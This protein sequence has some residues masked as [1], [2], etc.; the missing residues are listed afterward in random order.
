[1]NQ[2]HLRTAG[3]EIQPHGKRKPLA[4]AL[5]RFVQALDSDHGAYRPALFGG[6]LPDLAREAL[7]AHGAI[8]IELRT[9]RQRG[10]QPPVARHHAAIH[11]HG[12]DEESAPARNAALDRS[13]IDV[14]RG[15]AFLHRDRRRASASRRASRRKTQRSRGACGS[16]GREAAP[17][18]R[19][20]RPPCQRP[21]LQR[22]RLAIRRGERKSLLLADRPARPGHAP[23][24]AACQ[25]RRSAAQPAERDCAVLRARRTAGG[26]RQPRGGGRR[27]KRSASHTTPEYARHRR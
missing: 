4:L 1:M 10:D 15:V 14:D 23:T 12:F 17:F 16:H 8:A 19:P 18:E 7:N 13:R 2:P 25:R 22:Q 3:I 6:D 27:E 24:H 26:Q 9:V 5:L 21:G 11:G 20:V